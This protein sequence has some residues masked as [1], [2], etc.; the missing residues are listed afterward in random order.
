MTNASTDADLTLDVLP[1]CECCSHA[2][3]KW[4]D[5]LEAFPENLPE[6]GKRVLLRI[7]EPQQT[8]VGLLLRCCAN[9]H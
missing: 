6:S 4:Q 8:G 2:S 1:A 5:F 3:V 7:H 9:E